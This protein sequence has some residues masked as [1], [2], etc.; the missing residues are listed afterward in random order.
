VPVSCLLGIV[1][2]KNGI[3]TIWPLKLRT[4]DAT[5]VGYGRVD[6]PRQSLDL[7]IQSVAASTSF[8]AMDIPVSISG[9]FRK[10]HARAAE[11]PPISPKGIDPLHG[12]PADMRALA[13][14]NPCLR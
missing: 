10:L 3:G 8:F 1:D 9:D 6:L 13:Q 7:T 12:L 2:L 14:Q 5:L 4:P 11:G